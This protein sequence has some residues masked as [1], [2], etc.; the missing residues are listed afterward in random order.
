MKIIHII[1]AFGIG[2]AEKLLLNVINKQIENHSVHLIY[3]KPLN[4]LISDLDARVEIK[5][6]PFSF[7]TASELRKYYK[8]IKPDIIHT[9][10]GHADIL[11]IW[12]ARNI[13]AKVFCTMHNIYF[14]KNFLDVIFF[15]I[16]KFLFLNVVK[17]GKE[18]KI[19]LT[20]FAFMNGNDQESFSKELKNK[21]NTELKTL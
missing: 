18:T 19:N 9:H 16:Y 13:D 3:L 20:D 8:S 11:G 10:L 6:I 4:I 17:N 2:G 5:N 1:T 15:E 7:S 12:S 21:I 14:K